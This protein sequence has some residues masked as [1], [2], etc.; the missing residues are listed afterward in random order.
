MA[1]RVANGELPGMVTLVAQGDDVHV[2]R[3]DVMAFGSNPLMP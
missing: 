2:D 1:A 3:I